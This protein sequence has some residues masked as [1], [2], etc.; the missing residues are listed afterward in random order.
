VAR[1]FKNLSSSYLQVESPVVTDYPFTM[2]CWFN[3][4]NITANHALMW[5]GDKDVPDYWTLLGAWGNL[6]GDPVIAFSHDYSPPGTP[7]Q[8][9]ETSTGFSANKWY[10]ACGIWGGVSNRTVYLDGGGKVT[11]TDTVGAMTG[12]DRTAIGAARDSS[13]GAYT[14]GKIAEAAIWNA[15]LTDAE[16]IRLAAGYSPSL[17]RPQN[18]KFYMPLDDNKDRDIIGRLK[19]MPYG[20]VGLSNHPYIIYPIKHRKVPLLTS[21]STEISNSFDLYIST[22]PRDDISLFIDGY[23]YGDASGTLYTFGV[24]VCRTDTEFSVNYPSGLSCYTLGSGITT[25]SDQFDLFIHGN[26]YQTASGDLFIK[27]CIEV[28]GIQ[29]PPL[30]IRGYDTFSTLSFG[31]LI[32]GDESE[33]LSEGIA[34]DISTARLDASRFVVVYK[35]Q[36]DSN[37]GTAKIGIVSGTAITFGT[38]TEFLSYD[39]AQ[40]I[41]VATLDSSKFVVTY[42]DNTGQGVARIGTVSGTNITFGVKKEFQ[43][44]LYSRYISVA[45]FDSSKFVV[46]YT[47]SGDSNH[48]SAR[49]GTVSGTTITFGNEED[50]AI[51]DGADYNDVSVISTDKFVVAYRN[52]D[53]QNYGM[54]KIG[55]ISG[56]TITFGVETAFLSVDGATYISVDTISD[57][58]FVVAYRDNADSDHGTAKIGTIN[59]TTI[60][61]GDETEHLNTG[62][63][64]FNFVKAISE[65]EFLIAYNDN[66]D[67]DHGTMKIG[68]IDG[69]DII[70]STEK[71]YNS[72]DNGTYWNPIVIL[73]S[74]YVGATKFVVSYFDLPDDGHGTSK[75]GLASNLS[76]Q[77]FIKGHIDNI[78]SCD[79]FIQG[80]KEITASS[81]LFIRGPGITVSNDLFIQGYDV[82]QSSSDLYIHN[83]EDIAIS[84]DLWIYGYDVFLTKDDIPRLYAWGKNNYGQTNTPSPNTDFVAV[85]GGDGHGLG[86]KADGSIVTWGNN[87]QGQCDV[88]IPNT[89]FSEIAAGGFHSLGLK[90]DGSIVAWGLNSLGQCDVP[91]P[92]ASFSGVAAGGWHS[93]GLKADGSI[94]AWGWNDYNQCD[95]PAPNTNFI[96]VAGGYGHSLGL[97]SDG[98]IVAWGYNDY[99]QTD[100]PAPNTDFTEVVAGWFHSL[101]L[102]ADGSIVAWGR[103]TYGQC[104][105][106]EPNTD[107]V[108][109]VGGGHHSLALKTDGSIVTWGNNSQGQCDVLPNIDFIEIGAGYWYT[110]GIGIFDISP[111]LFIEGTLS[112]IASGNLFISGPQQIAASGDLFIYGPKLILTS[113]DLFIEGYVEVETSG[114]LFVEG[115]IDQNTSGNLIIAGQDRIDASGDLY[116]DSHEDTIASGDLF[117]Y[118]QDIISASGDLF[119]QGQAFIT[120][121][122]SGDLFIYGYDD[123]FMSGDLFL[124]G[125]N[126]INVSGDLFIYGYTGHTASDD[127][128]IYGHLTTD[129]QCNLFIKGYDDIQTSGN[130][131]IK[132]FIETSGVFT[133]SLFIHGHD[134]IPAS[135]DLFIWGHADNI[136]SGDLYII[137]HITIELTSNL[138]IGGQDSTETSGDLFVHGHLDYVDS[139]NLYICGPIQSIISSNLF[140]KGSGIIPSNNFI[141]LFING[142]RLRS[143]VVCPTLDPTASIQIPN[144]IITIYQSHIDA[145]INQLGKNVTLSFDSQLEQCPNCIYDAINKRSTGVYKQGGSRPFIRGKKCPYCYGE[146]F[147][148]T[149]TQKCIKCLI[150]WSP[151][152]IERY[153]ISIEK[154]ESVVRFKTYITE[155][156]DLLRAS[157][158]IVDLNQVDITELKVH[159]IKGP[160]PIG[161]RE[162]RYCIS[163][164]ELI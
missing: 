117:V 103:N 5:I 6:V 128:Y 47:D 60:T 56:T 74:E 26:D 57:T 100:V 21:L 116:I 40:F 7:A 13:P 67:S 11:D 87:S 106:P 108:A 9:A 32:F 94:I 15:V 142:C 125:H 73:D 59:D 153:G 8:K 110:L 112:S 164:W 122:T 137:S 50:F 155:M 123:T 131:F 10:H 85:A 150:K 31:N 140:I 88:P 145:L 120:V 28:S 71:E 101:G 18:L 51:Y 64:S 157:S 102:K 17:I 3:V 160:I 93:L 43:S 139:G 4:S 104:D 46:V 39:G 80:H 90:D 86:L 92:N 143:I 54:A 134:T 25:E 114:N 30:F 129:E 84:G 149:Y 52:K 91:I 68:M 148:E 72:K 113:G 119:I 159:R 1:S 76:P 14:D 78:A 19:L 65:T 12:H 107:F 135:G 121:S 98:S 22:V 49:V 158:A 81:D 24:R 154:K 61:F 58:K 62:R 38:E 132:G 75:V 70:F 105:V 63:V 163:F 96:A 95:V 127:L 156:N 109:V 2:S 23:G 111:H 79:L 82:F 146:G 162:D 77:L 55:T 138:F 41:S 53:Q 161:L 97:K 37:H 33:F 151:H 144:E 136:L 29:E 83:K 35:D 124:Y 126:D 99:D 34:N 89:G 115:H 133:P 27:G 141:T 152:D 48:G 147:L 130:L 20:S 44:S 42:Q 45:T 118:G 69:T 36:A 66:A 16:V